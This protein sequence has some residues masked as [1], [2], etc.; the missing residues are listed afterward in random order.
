[1][2][3]QRVFVNGVEL[4]YVEQGRGIPVV[5]LHGG[6]ADY[7]EWASQI[8]RFARHFRVVAYSRRYNFPNRNGPIPADHSALIEAADLAALL[9]VLDLGPSHIVGYSY[10]ALTAFCLALDEPELVRALVLME[11]PLVRWA[12]GQPGGD[13]ALSDFLVWWDSVGQAFR[14]GEP[15]RALRTSIDHF[16]GEGALDELPAEIRRSME[17]N[18]GDWEALTTSRDAFPMIPKDRAARLQ[19]PVLSITAE[20]TDHL[21]RIVNDELERILPQGRRETIVKA[22]HEML[23]EQ[24]EACA[25]AALRFLLEHS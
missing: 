16:V 6:L 15:D 18:L 17:D 9:R 4:H 2:S 19:L 22:T 5:L 11:P 3:L 21:M 13:A 12:A 14:S 8:D 1:V 10:G 20:H 7:R 23:A 24:P 25:K